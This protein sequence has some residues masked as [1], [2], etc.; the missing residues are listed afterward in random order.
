MLV[1]YASGFRTII[2]TLIRQ[3][4]THTD[5]SYKS[6][7]EISDTRYDSPIGTSLVRSRLTLPSLNSYVVAL[8]NSN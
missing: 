4:Y 3:N 6:Y 5:D 7:N 1:I 2:G 8:R